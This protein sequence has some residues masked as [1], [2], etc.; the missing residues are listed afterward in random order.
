MDRRNTNFNTQG[1]YKSG[2]NNGGNQGG[3]QQSTGSRRQGNG[4]G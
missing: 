3:F 1:G 2:Y 4:G